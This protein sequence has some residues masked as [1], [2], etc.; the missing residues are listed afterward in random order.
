MVFE[1]LA[2]LVAIVIYR[3]MRATRG[4]HLTAAQRWSLFAA[5]AVG[6]VI[7]SRVLNWLDSPV[8]GLTRAADVLALIGGQ[9]VVG[10]ILGGWIAVEVQKRRIGIAT[11]TGDLLAVPA[12]AGMAVGRIGCF[13][14]G[15][16]DGT[17]GLP[18]ALPW[19]IDLGDG[20]SR[21]PTALYE[22]L[23]LA[24]LA[25]ILW[26]LH[27][28][29]AH[30]LT[31]VCFVVAYLSFRLAVDM[32]KPGVPFALGLTA[33]QW[34]CVGGL[35]YYAARYIRASSPLLWRAS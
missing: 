10:A 4:D 34:A 14:T 21:H 7:G 9:T 19:G 16:S 30:G 11:S 35:T 3:A 17:H 20:I 24:V 33:I 27:G 22:S 18:T 12:A 25:L 29:L 1:L 31:F 26:R 2:F 8:V 32:L 15:L 28:R 13:L 23:F 5:L 6:A